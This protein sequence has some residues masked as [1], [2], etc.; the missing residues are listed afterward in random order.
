MGMKARLAFSAVV[1]IAVIGTMSANAG[2]EAEHGGS[3]GGGKGS[4]ASSASTE[5]RSDDTEG[6]N[7]T[8]G[9]G[10]A[11][12]NK[13]TLPGDGAH[14][15]GSGVRPATPTA[16][17]TGSAPGTPPASRPPRSPTTASVAPVT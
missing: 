3:G 5:H 7:D 6:T 11:S 15:V 4:P 2:R 17:A 12:R 13:A 1:G 14:R 8:A 16:A 9:T 10:T